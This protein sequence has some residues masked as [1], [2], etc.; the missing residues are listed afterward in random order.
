MRARILSPLTRPVSPPLLLG[1]VAAV[2]LIAGETLVVYPLQHVA[3]E[4]SLGV[5]YLPGVLLVSSVWGLALGVGT[6]VLST[7]AFDF[8]HVPPVE[9]IVFDGS[10]E[11][12]TPICAIGRSR[13]RRTVPMLRNISHKLCY[14]M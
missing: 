12:R 7:A 9:S 2:A 6:A 10:Q 4:I 13:A 14:L 5:V 11:L 3:P 8:F 1:M